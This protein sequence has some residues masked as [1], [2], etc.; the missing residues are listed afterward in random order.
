MTE[1]AQATSRVRYRALRDALTNPS[2]MLGAVVVGFIILVVLFGPLWA[3]YNPYLIDRVVYPHYDFEEEVYIR[4]PVNPGE[5]F[6]LGTNDIG[7]DVLSL[8]LHGARNTLIAGVLIAV[9]RV[10]LGLFIGLAAGWFE[11]SLFDRGVMGF[12]GIITSLPI[13]I[14][15][16]ILLPVIGLAGGIITFF[17]S[18]T[19]IGWTEV[20]QYIR[21][22]VLVARKMPYMEAARSIGLREIEIAIRHVIPNILP[23]LFVISFLE[24]G[25]VLMLL[26]E[27]ALF[28]IFIGG[29]SGLDL[30]DIM[31]P[32]RIAAI[33]RQPEWGAMIANGFRWLR[34]NPHM[35]LVPAAAVFVAVLGFNAVGEGLRGLFENR[36]IKTSFIISKKMLAVLVLVFLLMFA[37]FQST[38]PVRWFE[39]IALNFDSGNTAAVAKGLESLEGLPA[40]LD[41][42]PL[43]GAYIANALDDYGLKGGVR[44]SEFYDLRE[45]EL[46]EPLDAPKMNLLDEHGASA[47]AL[48][49]GEDFAFVLDSY[50]GPGDLSASLT[51]LHF[52][53]NLAPGAV[54]ALGAASFEDQ[55]V[56]LFEDN[57]PAGIAELLAQRGAAG[58]L[59]VAPKDLPIRDARLAS[60]SKGEDGLEGRRV[61]VFRLTYAAAKRLFSSAG[62]SLE[63]FFSTPEL[64]AEEGH[65]QS[66]S[67]DIT[68][69]YIQIQMQLAL[70]DPIRIQVTNIIGY[71]QGTDAGLG[72]QIVLFVTACDG[73]W[74]ADEP[75]EQRT[76]TVSEDCGAPLLIEFA[77]MFEE[78]LID[79]KRPI[80][81]LIWG[82]GE[83]SYSGLS[84]WLTDADNFSHLSAPGMSLR[85]R[86]EFLFQLVSQTDLDG[87][88]I[89]EGDEKLKTIFAGATEW[90][91]S[92]LRQTNESLGLPAW[93]SKQAIPFQAV[94]A[95]D[96]AGGES[97]S[98]G[99]SFSLALVRLVREAIP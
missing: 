7:M 37:I 61:P 63:A 12:S 32:P 9:G 72:N 29:G 6:L 80:M 53:P 68:S 71:L 11:G 50:G 67:V 25:A 28:G 55:I 18:L 73:L 22:E 44:W 39:E 66:A 5:D 87:L 40:A 42:P 58:V 82:G 31:A 89:S 64:A 2:L 93:V 77:R 3:P 49:Y 99:E 92:S 45:E 54:F 79:L 81:F 41:V 8:L 26:G 20:A 30:S 96:L 84:A 27:L 35:V 46:Y 98:V 90:G 14:S 74:R 36:G 91:G 38:Q 86:P 56:M 97:Q 94:F 15:A 4:V 60:T 95:L 48:D 33:P 17:V 69:T 59:W 23:Q 57:A 10:I 34:S 62:L 78:N 88:V 24:V 1:L 16:M 51:L 70:K 13:L 21:G 43:Y 83:F 19:L 75:V 47:L 76:H 52:R 85:P 65:L